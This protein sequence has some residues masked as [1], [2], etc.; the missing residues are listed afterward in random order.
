MSMKSLNLRPKLFIAVSVPLV[1][2]TLASGFGVVK[3]D[4]FLQEL[5]DMSTEDMP[6]SVAA[7]Q[8]D[9]DLSDEVIMQ[10]ESMLAALAHQAGFADGKKNLDASIESFKQLVSSSNKTFDLLRKTIAQAK[11]DP[12]PAV[13]ATYTD[14]GERIE[15]IDVQQ[16]AYETEVTKLFTALQE[17]RLT[18]MAALAEAASK[19]HAA[20]TKE[21]DEFIDTVQKITAENAT[22]AMTE[23]RLVKML[24]LASP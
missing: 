2:L 8:I 11:D 19:A 16:G 7:A 20:A 5:L 17:G 6:M 22:H 10:K 14:L 3:S 9:G 1:A 18:D 4:W 15:R 21:A 13:V 23:G 24:L 12:D